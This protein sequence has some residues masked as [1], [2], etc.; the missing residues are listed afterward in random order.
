MQ[1]LGP[2]V[3]FGYFHVVKP[4]SIY[5]C[6]VPKCPCAFIETEAGMNDL[7]LHIQRHHLKEWLRID[8]RVVPGYV[9]KKA[10]AAKA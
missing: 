8:R 6:R 5:R 9:K 2:A 4:F 1:K 7:F 3:L 10:M